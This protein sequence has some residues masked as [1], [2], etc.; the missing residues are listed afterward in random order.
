MLAKHLFI[1]TLCVPAIVTQA[2]LSGEGISI[3]EPSEPVRLPF[4][5]EEIALKQPAFVEPIPLGRPE[6]APR[7]LALSDLEAMALSNNPSLA[8]FAARVDAARGRWVQAGL[9]PNPRIGYDGSEIG[10][11]GH[12]GQQGGFIGQ[13]IVRG[14][15][16]ALSRSVVSGEITQTEQQLEA[17]RLRVLTDVRTHFYDVLIAQ[18]SLDLSRELLAIAERGAQG[19]ENLFNAN[20]A[21]RL[22]LLQTRIELNSAHINVENAA[23]RL[24]AAWR[25]MA[26]V[27]G[28]P[29]ME[30][31]PLVG[32]LQEGLHDLTWENSLQ[33]LLA[34]SPEMSA[35]YAGVDRAR[36]AL[37]R[38][39]VESIPNLDIEASVQHD[40]ASNFVIANAV[41][42]MPLPLYNK[43]QGGIREA[44]ALLREA[45]AAVS[46]TELDLQS[47]LSA[48]FER[49]ANA[50]NQVAR[51]AKEI[52]PDATASL[53]LVN[54]GYRQGEYNLLALLNAQ[55]TYAQVN[56]LYLQSLRDLW[57]NTVA[58]EGLLLSGSLQS[59]AGRPPGASRLPAN[60]SVSPEPNAAASQLPQ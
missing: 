5:L 21:G 11:E 51:Y 26:A 24:Q 1:A 52:L 58:I 15:K 36:A 22:D 29:A 47:R 2:Q 9:Y 45:R 27:L 48:A 57:E 60:A 16:L 35:A 20:E 3:S 31:L 33:T 19:A 17:Q 42:G 44:E 59:D 6:Q 32:N 30:P 39:R 53:D 50:K 43:N 7:G 54:V 49:Y 40:S 25:A 46:R 38:A 8:Q 12:G 55:R 4:T 23:N 56:L 34:S 41:V 37:A 28:S 13:E 18:E 10:N 14:N